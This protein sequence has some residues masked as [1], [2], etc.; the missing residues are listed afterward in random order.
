MVCLEGVGSLSQVSLRHEPDVCNEQLIFSTLHVRG[1]EY[2]TRVIEGPVPDWKLFF[3]W[4]Q[5]QRERS[6]KGGRGKNYVVPRFSEAEFDARFPFAQVSLKDAS[7]PVDVEL[8]GLS[9]FTPGDADQSSLPVAALEHRFRNSPPSPVEC[10]YA[11]NA[12]N[13]LALGTGRNE[14]R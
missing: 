11:F 9:P 12:A 5:N 8:S 7:M 3:P 2:G 10:V 13:F 14:I 1:L 4:N 6:G